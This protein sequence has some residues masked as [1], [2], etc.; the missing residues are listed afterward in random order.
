M[1]LVG[2]I[3]AANMEMKHMI[4]KLNFTNIFNIILWGMLKELYYF[5]EIT[6][7]VSFELKLGTFN[8]FWKQEALA[9]D[10]AFWK[11]SMAAT[12]WVSQP[13]ILKWAIIE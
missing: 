8:N 12:H 6:S 7:Q 11:C 5:K 10:L 1:R 9:R 4:T 13:D 3:N 2:Y